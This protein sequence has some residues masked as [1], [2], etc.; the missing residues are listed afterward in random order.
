MNKK[1]IITILLAFVAVAGQGQI[2]CHIEGLSKTY[3][4]SINRQLT[5][6]F[7]FCVSQ[8]G[9]FCVYRVNNAQE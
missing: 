3:V 6:F 9:L 2:K 7:R 8:N 1:T 5:S 4:D